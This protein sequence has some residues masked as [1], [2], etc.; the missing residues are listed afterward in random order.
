MGERTAI[1]EELNEVAGHLN[2]QHARLVDI[3]VKLLS[4]ERLWQGSGVWRAEQFLAW[5]TGVSIAR[6]QQ[7]VDIA[8]RAD[9]L[10]VCLATFRHGELALDQVAAVARRAPWWTDAEV[11]EL[12]KVMTV[13]QLQ[14][15]LTKYVF[16][17][18]PDIPDSDNP[19][20]ATAASDTGD[21]AASD[22][23]DTDTGVTDPADTTADTTDTDTTGDTGTPA[24]TDQCGSDQ[25]QGA[26]DA[27]GG[28]PGGCDGCGT[29]RSVPDDRCSF[30]F[31]DQGRF[32]LYLETD[33]L[34]GMIIQA[35]LVEARDAAFNAGN[36]RV[37]WVDAM[38]EIAERSLG[39]I[40]GVERRNRFRINIHLNNNNNNN[41]NNTVT[42]TGIGPARHRRQQHRRQ[43]QHQRH[44]QRQRRR[45][46]GGGRGRSG[47]ARRDPPVHHLR[48]VVVT[49][50]RRRWGTHLGG[51]QPAHRA[52]PHPT[53]CGPA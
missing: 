45:R 3:T 27:T 35:A 33:Q 20:D 24:G 39:A 25:L 19:T 42:G 1:D 8:R 50:V 17:D 31:D 10:P 49:G 15:T 48:R 43:R 52:R 34:T 23:G 18:I 2:A 16:P 22:T 46:C 9:E 11:T 14:R 32:R 30:H 44:R 5:R 28:G 40:P 21:T 26:G 29:G 6:A 53:H 38:R 13:R 12:A 4:D 51:S 47:V 7:I 41:N 36:H 37:D